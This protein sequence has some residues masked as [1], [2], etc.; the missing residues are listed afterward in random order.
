[1][2][3]LIFLLRGRGWRRRWLVFPALRFVEIRWGF[4]LSRVYW[5]LERRDAMARVVLVALDG[6]S[7]NVSNRFNLL[8]QRV[9]FANGWRKGRSVLA[10]SSDEN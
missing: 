4:G 7:L 10:L 6:V 9:G 1:M 5:L 8:L 3:V 2:R